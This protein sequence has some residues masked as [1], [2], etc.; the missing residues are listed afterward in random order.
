M[1]VA[2]RGHRLAVGVRDPLK[3]SVTGL[4]LLVNCYLE[5][6]FHKKIPIAPPPPPLNKIDPKNMKIQTR[7]PVNAKIPEQKSQT[8]VIEQPATGE[9]EPM[10]CLRNHGWFVKR[11]EEKTAKTV[12]LEINLKQTLPVS[13]RSVLSVKIMTSKG[14]HIHAKNAFL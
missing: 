9:Y 12:Y 10:R 8:K 1:G 13:K 2:A 7:Q 5:I 11:I 14:M 3:S 6:K 4:S